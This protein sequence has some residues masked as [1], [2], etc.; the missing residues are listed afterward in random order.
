MQDFRKEFV[1]HDDTNVSVIASDQS[2]SKGGG[3]NVEEVPNIVDDLLVWFALNN[4]KGIV[5]KRFNNLVNGE[6]YYFG[7]KGSNF[8]ALG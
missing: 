1:F 8:G 6:P 3:V 5:Q 7:V 4:R 2:I